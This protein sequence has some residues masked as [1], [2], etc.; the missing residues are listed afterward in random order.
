MAMIQAYNLVKEFR[1]L[2]RHSG[3]LGGLRSLFSAQYDVKRAV[4]SVT[5]HIEEGEVVAYLGPNGAG[6]STTVKLLTGILVPTSGTVDVAGLVPW[7]QRERNA[8]NIGVV[9]GQRSQLWWDLP[10]IDSFKLIAK[11]YR[12]SRAVYVQNLTWVVDTL[13]LEE[14][15]TTPVR[16][17]SLGQRMRGDLAAALLYRPRILYLDEP[18]VGM[19][20]VAKK[21]ILKAIA[22]VNQSE[23][24]TVLLTTHDIGDVEALCRRL[25]LIDHGRIIYDGSIEELKRRY[26]NERVLVV[27]C[28]EENL[29]FDIPGAEEID[30]DEVKVRLRF[31]PQVVTAPM[32]I[33]TIVAHYP[34]TDLTLAEIDLE[35]IIH[36]IYEERAVRDAIVTP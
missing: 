28:S 3:F 29:L 31:D 11:M 2:R 9:F 24:T 30:R 6:K 14:F 33:S 32:L 19:D 20:V 4:D 34:I 23:N 8:E 25:L 10:L 15:L 26:T 18:T 17:L 16:M 36:Q 22:E 13:Q 1:I 27:Q 7:R 5:F 12:L 35:S 21:R